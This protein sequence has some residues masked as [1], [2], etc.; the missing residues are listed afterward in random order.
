MKLKVFFLLSVI[1]FSM[2]LFGADKSD[3]A[4]EKAV[5]DAIKAEKAKQ[6]K[7]SSTIQNWTIFQIALVPGVP[8][9]TRNSAVYG[10]KLGLPVSGGNGCVGGIEMSLVGSTT[11][12]VYGVQMSP[13]VNTA[14]TMSG[15]QM[16]VITN[17]TDYVNGWQMSLINSSDIS[18]GVQLGLV[19]VDSKAMSGVQTGVFNFAERANGLQLGIVNI[20]SEKGFQLGLIN[21]INDGWIPFFPLINMSF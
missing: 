14:G 5:V 13:F 10:L 18:S 11:S 3:D 16:C 7:Y 20:S 4:N 9:V 1:L 17:A 6:K 8:G 15:L 2:S 21:V 19:N 12:R